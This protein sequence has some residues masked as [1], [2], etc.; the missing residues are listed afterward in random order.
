[1]TGPRQDKIKTWLAGAGQNPRTVASG[2]FAE[3]SNS[4][5]VKA[6]PLA[7]SPLQAYAQAVDSTVEAAAA[8]SAAAR[9]A[10]SGTGGT[11]AEG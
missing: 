10:A 5:W 1:M 2:N 4:K 3:G 8:S 6:K 9:T 11:F 7:C